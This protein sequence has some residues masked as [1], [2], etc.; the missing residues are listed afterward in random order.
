M[1]SCDKSNEA[2]QVI[3]VYHSNFQ[4]IALTIKI[5]AKQVLIIILFV[6]CPCLSI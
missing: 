2:G 5:I 1:C 6:L 4:K 3:D